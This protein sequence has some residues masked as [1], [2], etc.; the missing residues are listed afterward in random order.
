M[1]DR[2][3]LLDFR[4]KLRPVPSKVDNGINQFNGKVFL[5]ENRFSVENVG[6]AW[7]EVVHGIWGTGVI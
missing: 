2:D 1:A 5:P 6:G 4:H 7:D 3:G